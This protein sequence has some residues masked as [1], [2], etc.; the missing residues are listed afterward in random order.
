MFD[1]PAELKK[2]PE[3][4][5]VYIMRDK[6]DDIIY[7]G[8]AK[9]LKNRVRQYFQNSANHSLKVKQMVS[10]IDHFEYI[11]TGSE[12]EALI[13]ENNLIKKHNPKY[14]ILL[15]D[16]KTYPYIKVTTNE[17]FPRVFVTRKLLK[18]KNKY[19]GPFTN[20]SAVKENIALIDKIWQVR[21]CSK[22]FPRDIGKG[23]PCL[24][25]HIGQCKAV[26]T[27]KVSEE[28]YNKMIGEI[29]D[30]LG[31]KTENVVKSLTS[32]MLK[33]SAE[34]E[35][36]KAAEVRDTIESIKILNQKQI[37]ENLHIDDRDVIGF[38]RGIRECIMQIFFIRGGKITGREHFM[39]EE[40]EGVEDKELMTQFVQQFYS[41]TPFI[42]KEVILQCE[43]DD[44]DLI[45][46]WLSEQKG[47]RVNVLV[48]QKGERKS[49][50][51]MAQNNAKIVLDKF[52]AEIRREH[53]RTKGALEEIQKALNIDFELNR[54]ESYDISN[55]QGFESVA[56]MVVFENGLPKRS[57]YR[58]FKI[59]TIIGPDDYGSM[60]EV[61]TRRFTRYI[62]ET[63]GDENVKKAGFD[64]KPDM[65][66]L[67][68]GK[69]QIS[70]VQKA[71]TNL[72][73]Y[74]PVCGMV[75]DDR[76]RTRALMY[77][78]EEIELPYTSEGF[79]LL[80]RMQ[81]EVHRFAIEY[82][83][84]LREKKQVHSILDDISGIGSVRRKALMK[85]FGDI[86]AIRRA[87]VEELQQVDGMNIKSAEAVYNFFRK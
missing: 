64:K 14:N 77:N 66:F 86:N 35:F 3:S 81:D 22:I 65:I 73:L 8:K 21:R 5:G 87:E 71:L 72:N 34:M 9:I 61:I 33:Y 18:D 51:L 7:V 28:E 49:L 46:Q 54:I 23:R 32:K 37:I 29:L 79:K 84:K 20:S 38:A 52:G 26:C 57:D 6:T 56:S 45:S 44:F 2:L 53:K 69:G 75:K 25:Y 40:C 50:V 42:P 58:K 27:G 48:P 19:F 80:T 10:N 16:D 43:I 1:I 30:F 68:G 67:D 15:K 31:G 62:N 85:H 63:S 74:V 17:M 11:V 59:K 70:A 4:P 13:L 12:V 60:E 83:R 55:T 82:H 76:H 39:L 24:N 47:Q 41:G 78:G 36:E